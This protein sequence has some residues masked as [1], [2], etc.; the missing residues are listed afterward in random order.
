MDNEDGNCLSQ[1]V[2]AAEEHLGNFEN[3][4]GGNG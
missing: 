1:E 3:T 2:G 4:H